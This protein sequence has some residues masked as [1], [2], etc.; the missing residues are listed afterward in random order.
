MYRF[1]SCV[2]L[3]FDLVV[4]LFVDFFDL[5][6]CFVVSDHLPLELPVQIEEMLVLV[7]KILVLEEETLLSY[8]LLLVP[9]VFELILLCVHLLWLI[10]MQV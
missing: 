4:D 9:N 8:C 2:S 5:D 1:G 6:F 3:D 10:V 7:E